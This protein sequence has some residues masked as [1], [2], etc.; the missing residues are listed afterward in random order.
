MSGTRGANEGGKSG[1]VTTLSYSLAKAYSS[2]YI[3]LRT[4]ALFRSA[5]RG[6]TTP[7]KNKTAICYP[8]ITSVTSIH[9]RGNILPPKTALFGEHTLGKA[10]ALRAAPAAAEKGE[11]LRLTL[12]RICISRRKK[13]GKPQRSV[14]G[15]PLTRRRKVLCADIVR[16]L[17]CFIARHFHSA[18]I[19]NA[20][21]VFQQAKEEKADR[22]K[23]GPALSFFSF[24]YQISRR[25]KPRFWTSAP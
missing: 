4:T 8:H 9:E 14:S 25:P 11:V 24:A 16:I 6:K 13:R 12:A 1:V 5:K 23:T 17:K 21:V 3:S 15:L 10:T 22:M 19:F 7:Q 2:I 18:P 20:G